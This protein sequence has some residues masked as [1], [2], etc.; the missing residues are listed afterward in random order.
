MPV[1]PIL[2][3]LAEQVSADPRTLARAAG[4]QPPNPPATAKEIRNAS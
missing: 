2:T 4:R 3:W 1:H